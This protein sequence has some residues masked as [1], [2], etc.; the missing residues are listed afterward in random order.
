MTKKERERKEFREAFLRR[1]AAIEAEREALRKAGGY[2]RKPEG[3]GVEI[4]P[5]LEARL[6]KAY[7][8]RPMD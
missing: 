7:K 5:E 2:P 3:P 1:D 6:L 8:G 4:T